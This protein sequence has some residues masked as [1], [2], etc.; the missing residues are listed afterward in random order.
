MPHAGKRHV[1]QRRAGTAAVDKCHESG[2]IVNED[3]G[4]CVPE[5]LSA[6]QESRE[7][8]NQLKLGYIGLLAPRDPKVSDVYGKYKAEA[9]FG[10]GICL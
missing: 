7:D 10:R 2:H 8:N 9:A 5:H 4:R 6:A 3:Q 1:V